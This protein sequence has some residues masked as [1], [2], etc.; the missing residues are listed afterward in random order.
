LL[1]SEYGTDV[2]RIVLVTPEPDHFQDLAKGLAS[3]SQVRISWAVSRAEA[4]ETASKGTPELMIID[5]R[6]DDISG[7]DLVRDLIMVNAGISM[8]VVSNLSAE[9]FHTAAEG[10]GIMAQLTPSPDGSTAK[11]LLSRLEKI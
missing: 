2:L 6:V 10:L 7:L 8:A 11:R 1:N 3:N 4:I 9:D 5:S